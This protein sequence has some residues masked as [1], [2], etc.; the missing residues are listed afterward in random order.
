[1]ARSKTKPVTPADFSEK[2][3][4]GL[5]R[6]SLDMEKDKALIVRRVL[7]S[8]DT[9]DTRLLFAHY[10]IEGVGAIARELEELDP[11]TIA[12]VAMLANIPQEKFKA[13]KPIPKPYT[14]PPKT[15]EARRVKISDFSPE[16]FW[17]VDRSK[18]DLEKNKKYVIERVIERGDLKDWRFLNLRYTLDGIFN[19]AKTLYYLT[20]MGLAFVSCLS[21]IPKE[22]F[23]C[24]KLRQSNPPHSPW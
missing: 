24:Y 16:L 4:Q 11:R 14:P 7:E 6:A 15:E 19:V 2:T 17:D 9:N 22:E 18:L 13:Y 10:T 12:F 23:R 3:F 20:P 8:C 21:G 1:M 5:D